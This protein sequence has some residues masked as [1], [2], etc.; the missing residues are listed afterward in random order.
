MCPSH[1]SRK[2]KNT[3]PTTS[4]L[5]PGTLVFEMAHPYSSSALFEA[6]ADSEHFS[7]QNRSK[8]R[9]Q[10]VEYILMSALLHSRFSLVDGP[11]VSPLSCMPR[12]E[13]SELFSLT[14]CPLPLVLLKL[15]LGTVLIRDGMP[16]LLWK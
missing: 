8:V 3:R 11:S 2:Q 1:F 5:L 7:L 4:P 9:R 10:T 6:M 12:F 16:W 15:L 13:R 14:D